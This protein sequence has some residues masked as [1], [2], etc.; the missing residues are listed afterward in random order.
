MESRFYWVRVRQDWVL[1]K[2]APVLRAECFLTVC[3][4]EMERVSKETHHLGKGRELPLI[5]PFIHSFIQSCDVSSS[6]NCGARGHSAHMNGT[7]FSPPS[8]RTVPHPVPPSPDLPPQIISN[9]YS[10]RN[11]I[12]PLLS[13]LVPTVLAVCFLLPWWQWNHRDHLP[14]PIGW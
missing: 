9:T 11:R 13:M 14:P 12:S 3:W 7:F 2:G 8:E 5:Y 6:G 4:S 1:M 10:H